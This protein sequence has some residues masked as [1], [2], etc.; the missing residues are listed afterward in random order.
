MYNYVVLSP[1]RYWLPYCSVLAGKH[2]PNMGMQKG[3]NLWIL[4]KPRTSSLNWK[5]I[6]ARQPSIWRLHPTLRGK[7]NVAPREFLTLSMGNICGFIWA[8]LPVDSRDSSSKRSI[9]PFSAKSLKWNRIAGR[10]AA[11]TLDLLMAL[12]S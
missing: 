12:H 7:K 11:K 6:G 3:L 4:S 1:D 2:S 9:M 5:S 10:T 8:L